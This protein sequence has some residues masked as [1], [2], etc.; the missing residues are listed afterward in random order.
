MDELQEDLRALQQSEEKAAD[1]TNASAGDENQAYGDISN[2][3]RKTLKTK[4][5]P[6]SLEREDHSYSVNVHECDNTD[7]CKSSC[8]NDRNHLS[9]KGACT[10]SNASTCF[11]LSESTESSV[12][13]DNCRQ[14]PQDLIQNIHRTA[15]V[16]GVCGVDKE[17]QKDQFHSAGTVKPETWQRSTEEEPERT[18]DNRRRSNLL[19]TAEI[20]EE[21]TSRAEK[22]QT[23]R[24]EEDKTKICHSILLPLSI[25]NPHDNVSPSHWTSSSSNS[26]PHPCCGAVPVIRH[27]SRAVMLQQAEMPPMPSSYHPVSQA[28]VSSNRA[29][30]TRSLSNDNIVE[31]ITMGYK[32]HLGA[33]NQDFRNI[34]DHIGTKSWDYKDSSNHSDT[35]KQNNSSNADDFIGKNGQHMSNGLSHHTDHDDRHAY[36]DSFQNKNHTNHFRDK[37]VPQN[38]DCSNLTRRLKYKTNLTFDDFPSKHRRM[39]TTAEAPEALV[40]LPA[41]EPEPG[42]DPQ[43][44]DLCSKGEVKEE[45]NNSRS[46]AETDKQDSHYNLHTAETSTKAAS[47]SHHESDN[48]DTGITDKSHVSTTPESCLES[49]TSDLSSFECHTSP[50]KS[51]E[52]SEP[53][54][55]FTMPVDYNMSHPTYGF[56]GPSYHGHL[57]YHCL[58]QS[59]THL[60]HEYSSHKPSHPSNP[61][62]SDQSSDEEEG[63]G[64]FAS[65]GYNP[66]RQHFASGTTDQVLL[67]DISAK[68]AELLVADAFG[69]K[70][71]FGYRNNDRDQRNGATS[72]A[73]VDT[74]YLFGEINVE[75]R[76][77][78]GKDPSRPGAEVIHKAGVVERMSNLKEGENQTPGLTACSPPTVLES[79]QAS[80]SSTLSVCI[81][82]ALSSSM[83]TNISAHLSNPVHHPF[84]CSL[85]D[86]SFSQRGSLNRHVRSHLGVRPFPCPRCPMT[87]SRQY[88]V[89]EHMRVHQRYVFKSD[90]QKPHASST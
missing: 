31:G 30:N 19:C 16:H 52:I 68:P 21:E 1:N 49:V 53:H 14:A 50:E 56:V 6:L 28:P 26:S 22:T 77:S 11:S 85:C 33:Q 65:P 75:E 73:G 76:K 2:T 48:R 88:R 38:I 41:K 78:V 39:A 71:T 55:T 7:S 79:L 89:T 29:S 60:S 51:A 20:Q 90:F 3:Y 59:E 86:R 69:K 83:P 17:V 45:I 54:L 13:T 44:E 57:Q 72:I 70:H 15:E 46:L 24:K 27:S 61:D 58:P 12:N 35:L 47:Y 84:Q 87:F 64:T 10:L 43:C 80:V 62:H 9:K 66:L 74:N 37:S 81:P 40:P 8:K 23:N 18:V 63:V 82:S 32:D 36:Y 42:S 34:K 25:S 5:L 4:Y 67:L